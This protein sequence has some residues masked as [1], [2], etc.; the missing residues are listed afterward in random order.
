[1]IEIISDWR[2]E[3]VLP[4]FNQDTIKNEPMFFNSDMKFAL[5][6][7]G[8]ITK[9]FMD[10]LPLEW[11]DTACK[12][13]SRAHM[14]M[15]KWWPCIPGYHHDD[16]PRTR[17]DGQPNYDADQIRAE[18]C[19]ALINGDICPTKFAIGT[20]HFSDVDI[21][22]IVYRKWHFEVEN[23]IANRLLKCYAAPSNV[24]IFFN[25][26]AWHSGQ[27]ATKSGFRWFGRITRYFDHKRNAIMPPI[28][29]VNEIRKQVNVY[30]SL[31][32]EGW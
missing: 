32:Y 5:A 6:N 28:K 12:F 8:P 9:A 27:Q 19:M 24:L 17:P 18:H 4:E 15:P 1:M 29:T 22:D 30:L 11:H 31:P 26:R 25:D 10:A 7:G 16:V 23:L 14:L 21:G 20:A 3:N 2:Y 13:D